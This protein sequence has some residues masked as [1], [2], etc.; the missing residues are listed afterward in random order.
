MPSEASLNVTITVRVPLRAWLWL[1]A[2]NTLAVLR[3]IRWGQVAADRY[4]AACSFRIGGGRWRSL[5]EM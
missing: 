1:W 5:T 3:L 2:A 4:I